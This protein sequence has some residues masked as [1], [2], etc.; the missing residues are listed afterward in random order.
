[1]GPDERQR[2]KQRVAILTLIREAV[3]RRLDVVEAVW[4]SSDDGEAIQ[5]LREMVNIPD[6]VSPEVILDLQIRKMTKETR[7]AID[8]EISELRS[9]LQGATE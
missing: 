7:E 9:L 6:G 8:A 5:R 3:E 4:N 1:M 2:A